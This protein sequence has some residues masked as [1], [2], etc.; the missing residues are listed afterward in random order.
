M[1]RWKSTTPSESEFKATVVE[2]AE[3]QG[4]WV[5]STPDGEH[6]RRCP[7]SMVGFPDLYMVRFSHDKD[8]VLH[9]QSMYRELKVGKNVLTPSQQAWGSSL[10]FAGENYDVWRETTPWQYIE[11]AL[12]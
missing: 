7:V 12:K 1:T 11:E 10:M 6:M 2:Y 4:W 9:M 8:G 5:V 3:A